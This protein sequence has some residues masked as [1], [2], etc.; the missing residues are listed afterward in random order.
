MLREVQL[1]EIVES[2]NTQCIAVDQPPTKA[3]WLP[4]DSSGGMCLVWPSNF[5]SL[6][7]ST[8][9]SPC[10]HQLDDF[11]SLVVFSYWPFF[12]NWI[13]CN[14]KHLSV[15]PLLRLANLWSWFSDQCIQSLRNAK[16][17]GF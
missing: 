2:K 8:M 13:L 1:L 5:Y 17:H 7:L 3:T 4:S 10:N 6:T 11:N 16:I 15:H 14:S 9:A 12:C